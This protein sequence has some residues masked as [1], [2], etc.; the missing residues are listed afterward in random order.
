MKPIA[1]LMNGEFRY[2]NDGIAVGLRAWNILADRGHPTVELWISDSNKVYLLEKKDPAA[3]VTRLADIP[4]ATQILF[5]RFLDER[6]RGRLRTNLEAYTQAWV[7]PT[8]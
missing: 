2:Y 7:G 8:N 5:D 3:P 4:N 1:V 6:R